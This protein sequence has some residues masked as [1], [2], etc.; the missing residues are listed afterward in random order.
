VTPKPQPI[1]SPA[2]IVRI[3]RTGLDETRADE[4]E[5]FAQ[6]RSLPMFR[7]RAGCLGV[8]LAKPQDGRAVISLWTD[9]GAVAALDDDPEY[10]AT[11]EAIM[12]AGFLQGP[13][14]VETLEATAGWLPDA[15]SS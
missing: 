12:A 14:T 3:W 6:E 5:R 8:I 9:M 7:R 4:Y 11:V 10:G 13:Q 2:M 1:H 15:S